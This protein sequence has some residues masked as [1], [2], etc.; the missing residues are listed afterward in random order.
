MIATLTTTTTTTTTILY[1]RQHSSTI[2]NKVFVK[3][4]LSDTDRKHSYWF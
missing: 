3:L 4:L 2:Q 1:Y